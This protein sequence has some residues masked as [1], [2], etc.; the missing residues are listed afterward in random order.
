MISVDLAGRHPFDPSIT[1]NE[2][3]VYM[4]IDKVILINI[5]KDYFSSQIIVV[6]TVALFIVIL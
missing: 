4:L 5:P 1:F 6:T 2:V 3:E